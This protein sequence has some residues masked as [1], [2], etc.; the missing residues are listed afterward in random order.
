M[1]R[2]W[3]KW[4]SIPLIFSITSHTCLTL[5]PYTYRPFSCRW[6]ELP[7]CGHSLIKR[8]LIF[9]IRKGGVTLSAII[10]LYPFLHRFRVAT[11]NSEMDA[12]WLA[13]PPSDFCV[14]LIS[15]Y[16]FGDPE[17]CT[18]CH[19]L[20]ASTFLRYSSRLCA[21]S[22]FLLFFSSRRRVYGERRKANPCAS[23]CRETEDE[24]VFS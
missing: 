7:T 1:T 8:S 20:Q 9:V 16:I 22:F 15:E 11:L 24:C 19:V 23:N 6:L 4:T 3:R 14:H 2:S 5:S 21:I 17:V 10:I 13:R 12:F 18:Q